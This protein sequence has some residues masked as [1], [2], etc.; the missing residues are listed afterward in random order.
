[1]A[2]TATNATYNVAVLVYYVFVFKCNESE[3]INAVLQITNLN[4]GTTGYFVN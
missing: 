4:V 2:T 3:V 1:M